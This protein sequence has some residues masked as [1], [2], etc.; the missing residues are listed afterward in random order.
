MQQR[1]IFDLYPYIC[2]VK[3]MTIIKKQFIA[4]LLAALLLMV[5]GVKFFHTCSEEDEVKI[6]SQ[7]DKLSNHTECAICEFHFT[8]DVDLT[9]TAPSIDPISFSIHKAFTYSPNNFTSSIGLSFS[10]RGP[11]ALL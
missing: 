3:D 9:I 11:P 1:F 6:A 10:D 5:T 2:I 8:Q 7:L 4:G